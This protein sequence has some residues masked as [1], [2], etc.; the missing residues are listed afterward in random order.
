MQ[1]LSPLLLIQPKLLSEIQ[2]SP[3]IL[4]LYKASQ[5]PFCRLNF[6]VC[7]SLLHHFV[8]YLLLYGALQLLELIKIVF[9][10][11]KINPFPFIKTN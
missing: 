5:P 8:Y 11:K 6:S 4:I 2:F 10:E 7:E 3:S 1:P 9:E